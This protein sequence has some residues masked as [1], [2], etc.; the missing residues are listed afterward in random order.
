MSQKPFTVGGIG[1]Q[2]SLD[3]VV[4]IAQGGLVVALD[5]AGA[6]RIKKESPAPKAFQAEAFAPPAPDAGA[7][8][9]AAQ[10]RAVLATRL[11]TVMNGRSGVRL[12]VADF[13]TQLL[14]KP[15]LLPALPAA[16]TDVAVLS[17]LADACHGAGAALQT[18]AAAASPHT[19]AEHPASVAAPGG[20]LAE[21]L[22]AAG[23]APPSLSAAERAVLSSGAS[24]AAG[25]GALAVAGGKRLLST[26]T[27]AAALSVEAL[28][29][30]TKAFEAE[31]VEAAGYKGAIGVADELQGLLEGSKR[32]DTFK[33]RS[34]DPGALAAFT[35][36]P[37][38]LGALSE[39]L[40]GAYTAV[41]SEVQ[42]GALAPK[43]TTVLSPPSPLLP[44]SLV[45]LS[46][47]LLAAARDALARARAV[48]AP[49]GQEPPAAGSGPAATAAAVAEAVAAAEGRLAAA[50][51]AVVVVGAAMLE[52]LNAAPS[53]QAALAAN[54]AL[55]AALEAVALEATAAVVSLRALE[56]P[57]AAPAAEAAEA[58]PA[59]APAA[60]ADAKGGAG[61][62]G[63][64]GK[65]KKDRKGAGAGVVLG[66]GTA[67]L[68]AYV[69]RAAAGMA[70]AKDGVLVV[71]PL[72]PPAAAAA[73]PSS[74]PA[75]WCGACQ[76]LQPAG[77]ALAKFLEELRGVVE[78]NQARRKP[79]VPKGARDFLPEQMAIRERAFAAIVGV[80]KRHG[81]VSIDTPVFELRETLMGKYGEDSKLIYDL[82][83]QG[84]EILSLRYDLTV[85]FAR[86]VAVQGIT[87]IKRYHIGKVYRRDQP[88]MARGRFREF[89]QCDFDIAG[90]YSPMVPDAEVVAVLVEI[91]DQ[92][93]LGAFEVKLNHRGLL[94][95]ML[96]IAG[97][98]AQKFRPICSA[99]DKL[100]KEPWEAVRAE[101]VGDKGLPEEVADAIGQFVVL[102][103]E[104]M[105]LLAQLS[106][107]SHPLAQ[108]PQGKAA[109]DDLKVFFEM[110][111]AMGRL[112]PV[113]LDLSL[114]RGL[115]YYTGVIYEAVLQGANVGSIAA[116]GRYDRLVGMFSGK[117]VPAVGVSIGIERVFAIMEAQMRER[118]AAAGK[119]LRAIE[120]E[121]LVGSIGSGL[122]QRR[123]ALAA[124]LWAAGIKAEFGYKPNPKMADNLGY[125]HEQQVPFMVLF[126]EDEVARGVVKIKDMDAHSEEEVA[127]VELVPALKAKLAAREARLAAEPEAAAAAPEAAPEAAAEASK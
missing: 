52:D 23:V 69:E 83:D 125:C 66:K 98:P 16:P 95:A 31:V 100:D 113:T 70:G 63:G 103:G 106:E 46:R 75:A 86:F 116:G 57:P 27:A 8:L 20:P 119:P 126:G 93:R 49:P 10:T 15:G 97:V 96:A 65:A 87:N 37:Q 53:V 24:A 101:M 81:A 80:F 55:Q 3:D 9:D 56:G 62:K 64:E 34:G 99:I 92:L 48:A 30:S 122:Q 19:S 123:M 7:L 72:T 90:S 41:R 36:A 50:Q 67:L 39:A 40:A 42:S 79:K 78:A 6:E 89:F 45:E 32:A 114:A 5:A 18:S 117:D 29:A 54:G 38:R 35:A 43:G 33:D 68:R 120:T 58:A 76:A 71:P 60:P 44:T 11:M 88:Q 85:P 21:A 77:G 12:Q 118:A 105:A 112:G 124:E 84:G 115:D 26:A 82:A 25:V 51:R 111:Q 108:H 22:A 4:K 121:V 91:L 13:L 61:G 17:R 2:P 47:A 110:L 73:A 59:A 109:L 102:R 107:P 127:V 1:A 74:L 94:D 14:N 104:P 28:G